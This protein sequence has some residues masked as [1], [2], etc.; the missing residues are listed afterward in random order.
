MPETQVVPGAKAELSFNPNDF[1]ADIAKIAAEQGIS[2]NT[3]VEADVPVVEPPTTPVQPETATVTPE[4]T[5]PEVPVKFQTPEG[6][7]DIAKVEKSTMAADEALAKYLEKEKELKRKINEVNTQKNAYINPPAAIAP[8][9]EIQ[10]NM[11]F[12]QQLD[13]D[14]KNQGAGVVLAKLFTAAQQ[15][16]EEKLRG[17]LDGIKSVNAESQTRLQVEAIGKKDPWVYTQNG[18]DTLTK[19]LEDQPYLQNAKDPYKAAYLY[20]KGSQ[21]VVSQSSPQVLTPNPIARPSAPVQTGQ[22]ASQT[23]VSIEGTFD[24]MTNNQKAEFINKLPQAEQEK[25]F[26][27][28]GLPSFNTR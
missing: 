5:K 6:N 28:A 22:A 11:S 23:N 2:L 4:A 3:A 25:W 13:E 19:I 27:R 10:V 21:S 12:A 9:P 15:A 1:A 17:E 24:R 26:V 20:H 16:A 14:I 18:L 8:T 7:I